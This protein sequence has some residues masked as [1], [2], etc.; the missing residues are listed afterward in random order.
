LG[1]P[2]IERVPSQDALDRAI[3][4]DSG[5][6]KSTV[7][8]IKELKASNAKLC[9]KTADMEAD[10][11]NQVNEMTS[12]FNLKEEALQK[13]L[14]AKEQQIATME[15]RITS[16]ETRIRERDSQVAKLKEE[17]TFQRH[18]IADLKNQLYQLQHE[19][20]E[21]EYDKVDGVDKWSTERTEMERELDA[22]RSQVKS[23]TEE[24]DGQK[25]MARWHQKALG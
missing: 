18:T 2:R 11:M 8:I 1:L 7:Q 5:H 21:A 23:L 13:T 19:I 24:N 17:T 6:G 15:S 16:T 10:F 14:A 4:N 22:L 12:K 25:V 9:E 3:H 20:E